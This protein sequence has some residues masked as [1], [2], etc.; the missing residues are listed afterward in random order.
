MLGRDDL[1]LSG[2]SIRSAVLSDSDTSTWRNRVSLRVRQVPTTIEGES[3]TGILGSGLVLGRRTVWA[4]KSFSGFG[5]IRLS[6]GVAQGTSRNPCALGA[7]AEAPQSGA[8]L[9]AAYGPQG[10]VCLLLPQARVRIRAGDR[11][12]HVHS[13]TEPPPGRR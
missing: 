1:L 3:R 9:R 13:R 5:H 12:Q 2:T 7:P 4:S 11:N 10:P 6:D 8:P